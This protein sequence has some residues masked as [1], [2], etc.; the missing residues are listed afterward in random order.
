VPWPAR[1]A[2]A[3]Q[4]SKKFASCSVSVSCGGKPLCLETGGGVV[5]DANG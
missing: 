1:R 5:D 3:T 4:R 2:A